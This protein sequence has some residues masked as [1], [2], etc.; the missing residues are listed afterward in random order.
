M[1]KALAE[2]LHTGI[3]QLQLAD[4][5]EDC[6]ARLLAYLAMLL[7]WN[8]AYNLTAVRQPEQ[9]LIKHLLDSLSILPHVQKRSLLDVGTG[10]GLPGMV[11]ALA[12]PALEVTLL[13]SNGKKIRFLRQVIAELKV[14]NAQAVQSRVEEFDGSFDMV[15]SRAFATL[16]DMAG[17]CGHLIN[18]SG[19]FLAM[20]GTRPDE[21]MA[22][23]PAGFRVQEVTALQVPF[24]QE[25]RHLVRIVRQTD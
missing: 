5:P 11:L 6:E 12:N 17:W 2:K 18:A 13:D 3:E 1:D 14:T 16:A 22:D 23:L 21:E 20:K 7:R 24:L 10:A 8:E 9:M 25:Q 15:T 4:L 19:E